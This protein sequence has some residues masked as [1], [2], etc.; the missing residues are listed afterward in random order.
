MQN[1]QRGNNR[2]GRGGGDRGGGNYRGG[3]GGHGGPHNNHQMQNKDDKV[4]VKACT[5]GFKCKFLHSSQGCKNTHSDD[6]LQGAQHYFT[7]KK[8]YG[9]KAVAYLTGDGSLKLYR[10]D[11]IPV[12][13]AEGNPDLNHDELYEVQVNELN[14]QG[15]SY[16]VN[17]IGTLGKI[18]DLAVE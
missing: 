13:P 9:S 10:F 11:K 15:T 6:E 12:H 7:N 8:Y 17:I 16:K 2:G 5:S 14:E 4:D 18:G 3:R 1:N